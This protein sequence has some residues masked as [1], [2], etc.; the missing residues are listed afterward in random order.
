MAAR[1]VSDDLWREIEPLVPTYSPSSEGGRPPVSNR[2]VFTCV[3]YLLKTGIGCRDLPTEMV[4]SEK[5]VR[6]RLKTWNEMGLWDK[7]S[8]NCLPSWEL[9]PA[10]MW[11]KS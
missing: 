9:L 10:R 3:V 11:P 8:S 7:S 4:A 6:R 1:L 5:T 2:A